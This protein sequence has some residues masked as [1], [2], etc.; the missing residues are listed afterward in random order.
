MNLSFANQD[1]ADFASSETGPYAKKLPP[2][3]KDRFFECMTRLIHASDERAVREYKGMRMEKVPSE[4]EGCYS[5]RLNDQW[6]VVFTLERLDDE[7]TV[8]VRDVKDYH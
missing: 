1:L 2:Q 6:R 4:C 5:V 3:V 7:P 8:V